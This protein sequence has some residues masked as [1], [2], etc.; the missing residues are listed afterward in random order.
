MT[1]D[2]A[3]VLDDMHAAILAGDFTRLADLVPDLQDAQQLAETA[4]HP[5][6]AV[7][8]DKARRNAVCLQAA[9]S[10]VKSAR[11]RIADIADA[12]RGLTTYDRV[13]SKA[14]LSVVPPKLRR[15]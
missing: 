9:L 5:N 14:T 6:P 11:R 8:K 13:G 15:V 1:L 12:A 2:L 4:G 10:G 3:M 7:L